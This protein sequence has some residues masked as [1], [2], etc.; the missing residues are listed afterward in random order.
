VSVAFDL[1]TDPNGL[2]TYAS[3]EAANVF[4]I[5]DRWLL[6][7]PLASFVAAED[8]ARFRSF[9]VTL[10]DSGSD[11][12]KLQPRTGEAVA[13]HVVATRRDGHLNWDVEAAM[14][15]PPPPPPP[16]P[17][18]V[19]DIDHQRLFS[20]LLTR[21]PHGVVVVDRDL[22][23]VYSNPAARRAIAGDVR[24]GDALPDPWRDFSLRDH[25]LSLFTA[26]PA[27]IPQ[28]VE[29]AGRF[30]SVEG[31]PAA[32]GATAT[33][34]IEDV[35]ERELVRR[36][37]RRF[38]E[39]AAHELR[40]PLAAI[41][42]VVEVLESGAKDHPPTRDSFLAHLRVHSERLTRL[43]S[44]LLTLARIQTGQEHPQLDIV[45]IAPVLRE[46][47][48]RVIPRKGVEV[49]ASSPDDLAV[50][51][52]REL[53]LHALDNVVA[54]AIKHTEQGSIEITA[55]ELGRQAEIEIR[56]SGRGMTREQATA[57]FDRFYRTR[58]TDGGFGLGL[59]IA[60]EAVTALGGTIRLDSAPEQGTR[61]RIGLPSARVLT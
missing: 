56:D 29:S 1:V 52:N 24:A 11:D 2:I 44:S 21:L 34:L 16:P 46:A 51:A 43:T 23:L 58:A 18:T 61:V 10:G 54:N 22:N 17:G 15:M 28:I 13:A 25:A 30:Y 37:E 45:E 36:S 59:A 50:L 55:R 32:N 31:L 39:N 7:K 5:D 35:T 3:W 14:D 41:T 40:T 38:V 53:L 48:D 4:Q 60:H 47:T 33:V 8:R 12:L 42:S 27:V 6:R 49:T 57:A 9:L 19:L 26:A 20:R